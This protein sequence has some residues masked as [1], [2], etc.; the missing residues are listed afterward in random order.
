MLTGLTSL[1]KLGYGVTALPEDIFD[2]LDN[3]EELDLGHNRIAELPAG[4][5]DRLDSLERLQFHGNQITALPTGIFDDLDNRHWINM[6]INEIAVL[7]DGLF[8]GLSNLTL[9]SVTSNTDAPFDI[10]VEL[11]SRETDEGS[12]VYA[13][14]AKG[15]PFPIA[16]TLTVADGDGTTGI[17]SANTLTV[18]AGDTE[19]DSASI[20]PNDDYP[21][22]SPAIGSL[23][24]N[25]PRGGQSTGLNLVASNTPAT[26]APPSAA[27]PRWASP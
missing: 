10:V 8:T 5:F 17:L 26:E 23:S 4:I 14:V 20:T 27:P 15:A 18:P 21:D 13:T 22:A 12:E 1:E 7:P 16:V 19:S 25:Y 24:F 9:V 2:G 3:L 11:E 6:A